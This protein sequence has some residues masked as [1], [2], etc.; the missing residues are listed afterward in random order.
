MAL[1]NASMYLGDKIQEGKRRLQVSITLI[2]I[3]TNLRPYLVS[4]PDQTRC[5]SLSSKTAFV[6]STDASHL[7]LL[8]YSCKSFEYGRGYNSTGEFQS[9]L[10][11]K[12][13][14]QC[15][16]RSGNQK[17]YKL[18]SCVYDYYEKKVSSEGRSAVI[19]PYAFLLSLSVVLSAMI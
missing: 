14:G 1:D 12:G 11:M 4:I 18:K 17:S 15:K 10:Y 6:T 2:S 19:V 16:L 3:S 7:I 8:R 9:D 13:V 5:S